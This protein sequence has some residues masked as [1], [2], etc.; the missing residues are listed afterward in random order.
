[1]EKGVF[2]LFAKDVKGAV[3]GEPV[4]APN[5]FPGYYVL[6]LVLQPPGN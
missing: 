4:S 1:M 6:M 2:Y 5:F 3:I